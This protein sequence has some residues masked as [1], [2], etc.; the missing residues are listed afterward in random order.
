MTKLPTLTVWNQTRDS[1]HA[2]AKV[3]GMVRKTFVPP[4][5]NYLHL[6]LFVVP[7]GVS[8][9]PLLNG[10]KVYE[11]TLDMVNMVLRHNFDRVEADP[12]TPQ[13]LT[14]LAKYVSENG[15]SRIGDTA[16]L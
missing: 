16:R 10:D 8:T 5:P 9:G 12:I 4:Q 6:P 7:S 2:A 14:D 1:L 13:T 15:R 3:L 11:V